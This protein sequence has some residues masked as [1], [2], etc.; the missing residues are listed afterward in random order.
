MSA[1]FR[2]SHLLR[3]RPNG[4]DLLATTALT[5]GL[6]SLCCAPAWAQAAGVNV[7]A[8]DPIIGSQLLGTAAST[9]TALGGG[10]TVA[11]DGTISAPRY[12]VQGTGHGSV[13]DAFGATDRALSA[14]AAAIANATTDLSGLRRTIIDGSIGLVQQDPTSR[15]VT[16]AS[17]SAGTQLDITGL[18]GN[19]RLSGLASGTVDSDAATLGQLRLRDRK[20]VV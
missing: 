2:L 13:G 9:A 11:A 12:V 15:T 1:L 6:G 5:L 14:N 4:C 3:F 19:R 20:S 17:A 8:T 16:I 10:A 18:A 7:I